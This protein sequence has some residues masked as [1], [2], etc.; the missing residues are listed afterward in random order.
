MRQLE[1]AHLFPNHAE[2]VFTK[3][4]INVLFF[5]GGENIPIASLVCSPFSLSAT[6][7]GSTYERG[8]YRSHILVLLSVDGYRLPGSFVVVYHWLRLL[9][10][11]FQA[12][13]Q[14]IHGIVRTTC[15]GFARHLRPHE[16][17]PRRIATQ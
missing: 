1:I 3:S 9:V 7:P 14:L 2:K 13:P 4:Y 6:K 12:A 10:E 16:I 15:Q 5:V 11:R 8:C 17:P